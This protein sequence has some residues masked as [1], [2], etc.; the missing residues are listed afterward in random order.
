LAAGQARL[1]EPLAI[2]DRPGAAGAKAGSYSVIR[3][4]S[5]G[6]WFTF[7]V[8]S[9]LSTLVLAMSGSLALGK[10]QQP[11][12][13]DP[14]DIPGGLVSKTWM[15]GVGFEAAVEYAVKD[16]KQNYSAYYEAWLQS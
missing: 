14:R 7:R 10:R 6:S 1:P 12:A 16:F 3:V 2:A 13:G 4:L 8:V 11:V 9:R 5:C 15:H